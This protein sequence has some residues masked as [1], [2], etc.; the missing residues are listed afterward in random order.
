V[1]SSQ[2]GKDAGLGNTD[3]NP[4]EIMLD[5]GFKNKRTSG[6]GNSPH[7]CAQHCARVEEVWDDVV[8]C[9]AL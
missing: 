6:E 9:C 7:E 1:A 5:R 4:G 8:T 2:K 3:Y